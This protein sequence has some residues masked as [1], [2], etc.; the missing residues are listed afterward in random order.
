MINFLSSSI[1][2]LV[3][4]ISKVLAHFLA[5]ELELMLLDVTKQRELSQIQGIVGMDQKN[6]VLRIICSPICLEIME[7]TSQNVQ[8]IRYP[9]TLILL[10]KTIQSIDISFWIQWIMLIKKQKL[11]EIVEFS[12]LLFYFVKC[13]GRT[14][15][16]KILIEEPRGN[17]IIS[18]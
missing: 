16:Y 10:P 5:G 8:S 15:T 13:A 4:V 14:L 2:F 17:V 9:C 3:G 7:E 12:D 1:G 6:S 18:L 11:L